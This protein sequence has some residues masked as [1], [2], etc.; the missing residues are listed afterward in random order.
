MMTKVKSKTQHIRQF[1]VLPILALILWACSDSGGVSGKEMLHY[2]RYTANMEEV[3]RTGDMNE[4]DLKE[5]IIQPIETRAQ[6]DELADI[7]NRMSNAQK[8]SVYELPPYLEPI[9]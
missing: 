7:Y 6:Y 5:G 2:W 8:E 1:M 4:E 9:D 3:L